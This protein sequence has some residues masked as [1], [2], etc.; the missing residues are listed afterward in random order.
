M[1]MH[2]MPARKVGANFSSMPQIGKLKAL[3]CTA[4]PPRGTRMWV[5]AKPPFLLSGMAGP[6]W[7][8]LPE[9]SSRLPRLA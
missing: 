9:G 6:S 4:R 1:M 2:G 8:R 3:M 5:P 7:T